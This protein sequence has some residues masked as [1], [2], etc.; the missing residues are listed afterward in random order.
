MGEQRRPKYTLLYPDRSLEVRGSQ[1][2]KYFF[3]ND[4]RVA[5]VRTPFDKTRLI[6]GFQA[7]SVAQPADQAQTKTL[8]YHGDH[9]GNATVL[10]DPAGNLVERSAYHPFGETRTQS[11]AT[12]AAYSFTGKELDTEIGLFYYG[13]RYYDPAVGRFISVDPL[14][15]EQPEKDLAD[16]QKLNL[17]AY[18]L[19]NPVQNVDPDGRD[20]VIAYGVGDQE[21]MSLTLANRLAQD[22]RRDN[23]RVHVVRATDLQNTRVQ[24]GFAQRTITSAVFIGHGHQDTIA[25]RAQA[26]RGGAV[27]TVRSNPEDFARMAG[28]QRGGV[29]AMLG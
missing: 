26:G 5:E 8:F 3:A 6:H 27:A 15:F 14:Y 24:E 22:L 21:R 7:A 17:Y 13:A 18:A 28:V 11:D 19:N 4:E 1:L 9:L 2:V 16:P 23:I 29:V 10:V 20:V 25:L 12:Q